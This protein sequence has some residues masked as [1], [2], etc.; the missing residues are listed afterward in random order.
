MDKEEKRNISVIKDIDGHSIVVINDIIFKGKRN[1][2][3]KDVEE[4]LKRYVGEFYEVAETKDIVYIGRDLPDEYA[5]SNYTNSLKGLNVKAKANAVQSI[6]QLIQGAFG[7]NFR[8]NY[9]NKHIRDAKYG[10]FR[11]SSRFALPIYNDNEEIIRYNIFNASL[12]VRCAID[13]KMYLYDIIDIKKKRATSSADIIGLP[14]KKP[15]S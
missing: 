15:I 5:H 3:W 12:L 2:N 9:A 1:I 8:E 14:S 10:W 13:G 7:K 4:Y 6:P 11:F